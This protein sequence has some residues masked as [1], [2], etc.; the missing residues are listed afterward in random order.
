ML[1]ATGPQ[2]VTSGPKRSIEGPSDRYPEIKPRTHS[3]KTLRLRVRA[4]ATRSRI[5]QQK[6]ASED[7]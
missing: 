7:A 4:S 2:R 5:R 1:I 3:R 6:L